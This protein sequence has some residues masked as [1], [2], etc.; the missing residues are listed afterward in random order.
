MDRRGCRPLPQATAGAP[1]L[2][3]AGWALLWV[4]A[5]TGVSGGGSWAA[6]HLICPA[7]TRRWGLGPGPARGLRHSCRLCPLPSADREVCLSTAPWGLLG[8][9]SPGTPRLRLCR[10]PL[11]PCLPLP[12]LQPSLSLSLSLSPALPA[13]WPV[14]L[15]PDVLEVPGEGAGGLPSVCPPHGPPTFPRLHFLPRSKQHEDSGRS[16]AL[17]SRGCGGQSGRAG[18]GP[19]LAGPPAST[20]RHEAAVRPAPGGT[21]SPLPRRARA[22]TRPPS[23]QRP[24]ALNAQKPPL[25]AAS[26][27]G[28]GPERTSFHI[29]GLRIRKCSSSGGR[30][31]P[32][33]PGAVAA[34]PSA[35]C[36][37]LGGGGNEAWWSSRP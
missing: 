34:S 19:G 33:P 28:P 6:R 37:Q 7:G 12:S 36:S 13:P 31:R 10:W 11:A 22:D 26:R 15:T 16:T 17:A 18:P 3:P 20:R 2:T 14:G 30:L 25:P 27:A 21:R 5:G 8:V 23:G 1:E 35:S 9:S 29:T 4:G 32:S 24:G